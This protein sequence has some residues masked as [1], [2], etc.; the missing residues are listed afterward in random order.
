M[1]RESGG[2]LAKKFRTLGSAIGYL[3]IVFI[4]RLAFLLALV[5][6][7]KVVEIKADFLIG[8]D[9]YLHN[10]SFYYNYNM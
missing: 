4:A 6:N 8:W 5:I 3:K 9:T 7:K 10:V 1:S 2:A